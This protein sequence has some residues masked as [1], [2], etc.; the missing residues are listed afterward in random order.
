MSLPGE[1]AVLLTR[2]V[3]CAEWMLLSR[4]GELCTYSNH[5]DTSRRA[6]CP[7]TGSQSAWAPFS[8][9]CLISYFLKSNT[10]LN[11]EIFLLPN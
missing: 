6:I 8:E 4:V 9:S 7:N 5:S 1:K 10:N 2:M 3:L 11:L